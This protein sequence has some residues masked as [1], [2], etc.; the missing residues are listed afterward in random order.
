MSK[1]GVKYIDKNES[2]DN[3][4][5]KHDD[6]EIY[7]F[8]SSDELKQKDD[9]LWN[10]N[11]NLF[12][13]LIKQHKNYPTNFF[14]IDNE[15]HPKPKNDNHTIISYYNKGKIISKDIYNDRK[16]P[17]EEEEINILL[18]GE[19]GVGKS[20]FINAF[21]NY[22]SF[23][24]MDE[25]ENENIISLIPANFTITDENDRE[26]VVKIGHDDGNENHATIGASSTQ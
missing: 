24:R 12:L 3:I 25:A 1:K 11:F 19:T 23:N 4:L 16:P 13:D 14:M 17:E 6:E 10:N 18:L 5:L 21:V 2:L 7:I 8:H 20:T 15:Y 22:L 9:D 26:Y